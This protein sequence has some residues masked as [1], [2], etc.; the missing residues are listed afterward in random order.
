MPPKAEPGRTVTI[1]GTGFD[2]DPQKNT[3]RFGDQVGVVTSANP[4][5]LSVTVPA[6]L[7]AAGAAD[8]PV[9]VENRCGKSKPLSLRVYRAPQV[10]GIQPDVAMPGDEITI[11]GLN[12]DGKPLTVSI[13]GMARR[14]QGGGARD[15]ARWWCRRLPVT[16]GKTVA[17]NVQIGAESAKPADLII[18]RLPLVTE[19]TPSQGGRGTKGRD[20]GTGLRADATGQR[21]RPSAASR[22]SCFDRLGDRADRGGARR[23]SSARPRPRWESS[24]RPAAA[25]PRARRPSCSSAT[26]PRPSCPTSSRARAPTTPRASWP[27]CR[28]TSVPCCC[29]AAKDQAASAAERAVQVAAALE[30]ARGR[31]GDEA[32]RRSRI[33]RTARR[34]WG[35]WAVAAPLLT[36]TAEDAAAYDRPWERAEGPTRQQPAARGPALGG[37]APGLLQ[38][39]RLQA[40]AR[41]KT[42]ELSPRGKVL[43]DIYAEALRTAGP[44]N[45]VPTRGVIP[46]S[47]SLAKGLRELALVLPAEG[48]TR[49]GAALEG[50]WEGSM[51]EGSASRRPI[52]VR[53]RYDGA[54]LGGT[55]ST[56][57]GAAEMNTPL[58]D[59]S[60]NK[61]SLRFT[62][63]VS[64]AA[65][66]L[67]GNGG[68]RG[69]QR[70]HPEGARTSPRRG[71]SPSSSWNEG[72]VAA[73]VRTGLDQ[74][75]RR[76]S[77]LRGLRLGLVANPASVTSRLVHAAIALARTRGLRCAAL[78]GPE[79]GV[80]ADAQ[81]LV[82]VGDSRDPR[83]GLPVHSLYGDTR[84]PTAADAG[85]PRRGGLRHAG[86][87]LAL[88]HVRL[89]HAA[90]A[91]GLR[92]RGPA[93]RGARPA[94]SRSAARR[95]TATCSTPRSRRSWACTRCP[96][97]T[98]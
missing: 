53:L 65:A 38:P 32:A 71:A 60:L 73:T 64:G 51:A 43:T 22:R 31:G 11:K 87:G 41:C 40:S 91:R 42:L 72:A 86:R 4:T 82:E 84:V 88:L 70:H 56:R 15:A 10:S 37:P 34:P 39:V 21:G 54:R 18:G 6:R 5:Q 44:G 35:S 19:V 13:S 79:H 48:Q 24:S 67:P 45:G 76:P 26:R 49:A 1:T 27:S 66:R 81:D 85:R 77:V 9:V 96:C 92:A 30:R 25:R 78:F 69:G 68:G 62:V 12:L 98:A 74:L 97:A 3:V 46:P 2:S 59:V 17:V 89:H 28:P 14:G 16:E 94:Q 52:Q 47:S 36:A 8:V 90:R 58:K 29:S 23:P 61:G 80:W 7:A 55:L 63:D 83:T 95:W 57:A 50:L 20:Q 75:L 33:G 93:G